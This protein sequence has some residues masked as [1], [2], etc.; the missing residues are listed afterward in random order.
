MKPTTEQILSALNKMIQSKTELKT[1]KIELGV[2]DLEK[3]ANN[4]KQENTDVRTFGNKMMSASADA[5]ASY[6]AI[7]NELK[8]IETQAKELGIKVNDIPSYK[9]A[10]TELYKYEKLAKEFNL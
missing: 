5:E 4:L 8:S 9:D 2:K 10:K 1:E 3:Y 6:K 7:N